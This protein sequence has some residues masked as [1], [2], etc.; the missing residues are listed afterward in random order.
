MNGIQKVSFSSTQ[1]V[2]EKKENPQPK[3]SSNYLATGVVA[4]AAAGAATAYYTPLGREAIDSVDKFVRSDKFEEALKAVPAEKA[5]EVEALKAE[6]V[7]DKEKIAGISDKLKK[8]FPDE[9]VKD[10]NIEDVLKEVGENH[11]LDSLK[12]VAED[13][14]AI[15]TKEAVLKEV[16]KDASKVEDLK[17]QTE[18][19]AKEKE[20][21]AI[22]KSLVEAL[23]INKDTAVDTKINKESAEKALKTVST[24][25]SEG[26][27]KAFENIKAHLPKTEVSN[28]LVLM[29]MA[30]AAAVLGLIG[31]MMKKK[32]N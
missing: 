29:Y 9:A 17:I 21:L 2:V 1:P 4:G 23:G 7:A 14:A 30:G 28:K 6:Q 25:I 26:A 32:E 24:G 12:K 5:T 22:K 8:L 10:V 27:S 13:E 11:S 16:A 15:V 18:A 3:K 31:Y 20:A 19:L